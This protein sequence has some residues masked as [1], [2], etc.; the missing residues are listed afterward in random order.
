GIGFEALLPVLFL[1]RA[2]RALV[3]AGIQRVGNG[4]AGAAGPAQLGSCRGNLLVAQRRTMDAGAVPLVRRA[5]ADDGLATDQRRAR[6][7]LARVADG[8]LDFTAVMAVDVAN[9][10][11]A[12]G[13]EA[14][15][16][17]I[18]EPALGAAIDGNAVVVVEHDQLAQTQRAGQG[19]GFVA[20]A[21]HEA[22]VA[23]KTIGVVIDNGC[24]VI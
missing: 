1:L 3:P 22:A 23:G 12:V 5:P 13:F 15:R 18:G 19:A 16:R 6:G 14:L 9:H 7:F 2:G 8:G 21:F 24:R 17:V 20:D 10:L 11:P 4:E